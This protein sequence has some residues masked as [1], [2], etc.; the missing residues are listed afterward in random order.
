[1]KVYVTRFRVRNF[2]SLRDVCIDLGKFNVFVG[3]NASGKSN[4]VKA[5]RLVSNHVRGIYPLL[6]S[7]QGY[8][9][10]AYGFDPSLDMLFTIEFKVDDKHVRYEL[11]LSPENYSEKVIVEDKVAL[12]AEGRKYVINYLSKRK[13]FLARE[14]LETTLYDLIGGLRCYPSAL[15]R[16]PHDVVE[17]VHAIADYL[18]SVG[19]YSF[20]PEGIR[21]RANIQ[22]KPVLSYHGE[23]LARVLLH[24]FLEDR[25]RFFRI[26]ETLR[27]LIPEVESIIPHL[28]EGTTFVELRLKVKGLRESLPPHN[29]SDGTLRILAFITALYTNS[30]LV[31]FEE[32][33]NC[34]HPYLLETLVDLARKA[35]CQVIITTHSPYLLDYVKVSELYVVEKPD[36]ETIVKR[37]SNTRE[38][39][40]VRKLLEEGGTLGEAWYSGLIGGVP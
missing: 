25:E 20:L 28:V 35:P 34:I 16:L 19:V 30:S 11:T 24:L 23:N 1:M 29:I 38:V 13:G 27:G 31:T 15:C 6:P 21:A 4:I 8:R 18:K 7:Y 22:S 33:E 32:P 36:L 3:P 17:E 10:I 9:E 39:E 26:E 2:L 12:I 14:R 37:V 40:A 5:L